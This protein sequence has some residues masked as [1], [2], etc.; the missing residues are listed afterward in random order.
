MEHSGRRH[1]SADL[2]QAFLNVVEFGMNVQQA[3]EAP[4]ALTSN[5]RVP[6]YPQN[7]GSGLAMPEFLARRV[8]PG[9]AALGHPVP[10]QQLQPPYGAPSGTG[11]VKMILID[12]PH[13]DGRGAA[14][15]T[16]VMFGGASPGKDNYVLGW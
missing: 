10:P 14:A 8:G 16:G 11:A 5:F 1:H 15:A 6:M 7:P 13:P 9:L 4:C 3:V 2:T 12:Q